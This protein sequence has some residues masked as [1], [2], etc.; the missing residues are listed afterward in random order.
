MSDATEHPGMEMGTAEMCMAVLVLRIR[1][2][3]LSP[4]LWRFALPA[5]ALGVRGRDPDPP[6]LIKLSIQRC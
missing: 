6:S 2:S 3:R 1:A 5:R 4:A